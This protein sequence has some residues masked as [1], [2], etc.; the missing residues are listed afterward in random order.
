MIILYI[1]DRLLFRVFLQMFKCLLSFIF[2]ISFSFS[3]AEY[4]RVCLFRIPYIL[5]NLFTNG[6]TAIVADGAAVF[7]MIDW[8]A[9]VFNGRGAYDLLARDFAGNTVTVDTG[10]VRDAVYLIALQV[11]FA[12]DGT[13]WG[14]PKY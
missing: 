7:D 3:L 10:R 8:F 14:K 9:V 13:T 5:F 4:F 2:F 11:M 6:L 1:Y 12:V